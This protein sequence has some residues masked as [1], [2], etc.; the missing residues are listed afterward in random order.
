MSTIQ[1]DNQKLEELILYICQESEGD[2][3]FGATK[4]N[5]V[6]FYTD[7]LSYLYRG[8]SITG[9][10]YQALPQGPAPRRLIPIKNNLQEKGRLIVKEVEFH[11][12]HQHRPIALAT[13]DL[14]M[15][16]GNEI[17]I[18]HEVIEALWGL[19]ATDVSRLSHRF[20]GWELAEEGETIP[21]E[22]ALISNREPTLGERRRMRELEQLA[23]KYT[24]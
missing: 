6:L 16:D 13:P 18:V 14:S 8:K 9:Q 15:F 23:A 17:A 7:F 1:I 5:K 22:V 11:G 3:L 21:Y 2:R 20:I 10:E 4:L 24:N 19:N 12:Y